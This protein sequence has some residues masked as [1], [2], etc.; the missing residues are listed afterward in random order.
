[1]ADVKRYNLA[2]IIFDETQIT[3]D[4]FKTTRKQEADEYTATNSHNPYA[5]SFTSETFEW[6]LTDVDPVQRPIFSDMM[7]AQQEHPDN[8]P[9]IATYDFNEITGDLVEDDVYYDAYIK[10]ISKENA[11]NPFSVKGQCLRM[12]K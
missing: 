10:E 9:M 3:T 6:E 2:Q 1:M 4:K 11:N 5:I 12:K 8:L 7:T